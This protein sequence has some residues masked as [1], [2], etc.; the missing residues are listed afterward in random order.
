MRRLS[1]IRAGRLIRLEEDQAPLGPW[2]SVLPTTQRHPR[3]FLE[4]EPYP[5]AA[6]N[7]SSPR[8]AT[9]GESTRS[10]RVLTGPRCRIDALFF[11]GPA[12]LCA[13]PDGDPA[14]SIERSPAS[15]HV[16][17]TPEVAPAETRAVRNR[18]RPNP[19]AGRLLACRPSPASNDQ[20]M[21]LARS[22]APLRTETGPVT[23]A[24]CNVVRSGPLALRKS[25]CS[26][27]RAASRAS[28][29]RGWLCLA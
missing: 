26:L 20:G 23:R 4:C 7:E 14:A 11:H 19:K 13:T 5:C 18:K 29:P 10:S 12:H 8:R 21:A 17:A 25:A 3:S 27:G 1:G 15:D 28:S 24:R 16:E 9:S 6:E 22:I 2:V